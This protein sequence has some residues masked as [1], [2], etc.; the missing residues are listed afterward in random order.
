MSL[1]SVIELLNKQKIVESML[2]N[3]PMRRHDLVE[4][5]V[6]KQ[7][8]AELQAILGR[9]PAAE[10]GKTIETLPIEDARLLWAQVDPEREED[11]LW[12]ISDA[13]RAQL[14]GLR[15]PQVK[16]GQINAYELS[17]DRVRIVEITCRKDLES[18]RPIWIDLLRASKS[19]RGGIGRY[20]GLELPDPNDLT[21]LEASA[22]FYVEENDE[23]HLH[24]NFLL[25]RDVESRSVPVAFILRSGILFTVRDEELPVFRLQ[26]FRARHRP[27]SFADCK[28][29][30]LDL[31]DADVEYSADALEDSYA[32][33]RRVGQAVLGES[34]SDAD[35]SR[36][37]ADITAEED[38]NGLIRSNM[39]DTQRAVSFLSRSD[40]L[41]PA[42]LNKVRQ[43]LRDIDS[44][45]S[46]TAFLFEKINFLM[47]ATI[48]FINVNQ[49]R[50]VSQLTVLGV[51]FMPLNILAGIGG[52][53]EF[54]MMT[55]GIPWPIAYGAFSAG[56]L[57]IGWMTYVAL[58]YIE[59]RKSAD[60]KRSA[61]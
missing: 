44:L 45:N 40:F 54:S 10:I 12:E 7:H 61:N 42:Q 25:G 58:K 26:R 2:H 49:N 5:V 8:L 60:K 37:L 4:T 46:H 29:L 14:V 47:D 27:G 31:Y 28:E 13:R 17:D 53:S 22:R 20:Y 59:N 35:A 18:I 52:M 33:L 51:V 24:S 21:D 50:R 38:R 19:E 30:L 3:Q 57:L 32:S 41:A 39:L 11:I 43:I 23:I 55:A 6:H 56:M 36:L 16:E 48:G 34:V 9:L 1:Q 15:E